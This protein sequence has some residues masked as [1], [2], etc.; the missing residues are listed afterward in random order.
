MKRITLA[1]AA[2]ALMNLSV[3]AGPPNVYS[4]DGKYL[5]NLSANKFDPN[6]VNN[7][8]GKY[9]SKF[10]PDSVNNEFGRYGSKFSNESANNPF[11]TQAPVIIGD[12]D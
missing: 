11:A 12:D 1:I 5:G 9:G 10:S 3:Y 8:F 2:I 7:E 4:H 6:S